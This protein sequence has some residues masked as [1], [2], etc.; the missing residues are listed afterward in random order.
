MKSTVN[1]NSRDGSSIPVGNTPRAMN[2]QAETQAR[3]QRAKEHAAQLSHGID[4]KRAF[5]G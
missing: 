4:R 5:T 2:A 3:S 1:S